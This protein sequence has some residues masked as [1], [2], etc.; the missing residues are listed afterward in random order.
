[1]RSKGMHADNKMGNLG[2]RTDSR[3][4]ETGQYTESAIASRDNGVMV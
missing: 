4:I 2:T 1:M 3:C